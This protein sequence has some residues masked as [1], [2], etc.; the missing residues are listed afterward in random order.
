M[1][2]ICDFGVQIG[3]FV[4]ESDSLLEDVSESYLE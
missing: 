3:I 2:K 4:N 1:G